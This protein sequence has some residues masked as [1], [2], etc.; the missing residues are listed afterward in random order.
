M[1]QSEKMANKRNR[2]KKESNSKE[3]SYNRVPILPLKNNKRLVIAKNKVQSV[4]RERALP[5]SGRRRW[6]G[7]RRREVAV[8]GE[9]AGDGEEAGAV[10]S[11]VKSMVV[12]Q[13][14]DGSVTV[15]RVLF[16]AG[17][18]CRVV[19]RGKSSVAEHCSS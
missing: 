14:R 15:H 11:L 3:F 8:A 2:R 1:T 17:F 9:G 7:R 18:G 19:V 4:A 16:I 13:E 12:A 6:R 5:V 10:K